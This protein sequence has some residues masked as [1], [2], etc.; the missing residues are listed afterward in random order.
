MKNLLIGLFLAICL[1][2]PN[3]AKADVLDF[4]D[5]TTRSSH[6]DWEWSHGERFIENYHGFNIYNARRYLASDWDFTL[7]KA[8][9]VTSG[10]Y[11]IMQNPDTQ[12][13]WQG[14]PIVITRS[15]IFTLKSLNI[16]AITNAGLRVGISGRLCGI[17]AYGTSVTVN[18][19]GPTHIELD[20]KNITEI[21]IQ[22]GGGT[23]VCPGAVW[24]PEQAV[25]AIAIDDFVYTLG[26]V[27]T[28]DEEPENIGS[29]CTREGDN[30][31]N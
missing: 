6:G 25:P 2:L 14:W 26:A 18:P 24:G 17:S 20:W 9:S 11:I 27:F 3:Q 22:S 28:F 5:A 13:Y 15:E 21:V 10:S 8:A 1:F 19:Y 29:I 31:V 16:T 7:G 23:V 12:A 4:E 30:N